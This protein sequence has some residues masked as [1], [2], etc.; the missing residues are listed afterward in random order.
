LAFGISGAEP[1]I[2]RSHAT[3]QAF[4]AETYLAVIQL[5]RSPDTTLAGVPV[6]RA[7]PVVELVAG[8]VVCVIFFDH[9]NASDAMIVGVF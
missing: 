1:A 3:L 5:D 6:S 2:L 9:L 7:I 8:R 4:D